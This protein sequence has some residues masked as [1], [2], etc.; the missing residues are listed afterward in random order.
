MR[1]SEAHLR[2][3][4][5]AIVAAVAAACGDGGGGGVDVGARD[6]RRIYEGSFTVLE[7]QDH[8]PELCHEVAESMPPQCGG[9]PIEGWDWDAVADEQ[10][11]GGTTWGHWH[12]TG[13]YD[14]ERFTL[15]E[16]PEPPQ[17]DDEPEGRP[18]FS[19][20][21]DEPDV[22]DPSHAAA[23]WEAMTQA[24][25]GSEIPGLVAGWVSD[26]AGDWDGP[27]VGSVV[28]L[29][30]EA[31]A[32]VAL[33]RERYDGPLCVVERE[34]PTAA[35]LTAVGDEVLDQR[36]R[37]ALGPVQGV[38]TDER[39]GVVVATVWVADDAAESY[40]QRRW[41]DLVRLHGLLQ[42]A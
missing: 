39:R 35:E 8:G 17:H 25:D 7:S 26:P 4:T 37:D 5:L 12:V 18:D 41:C 15:V 24:K 14:G 3:S 32:A 6:A 31:P 21:C 42:P 22:V 36:A 19:P 27:F 13:T 30:G 40:A 29:P 11:V 16:P 10:M 34:A 20:A 28:V 1:P 2:A 9:V 38:V 33:I 23:E